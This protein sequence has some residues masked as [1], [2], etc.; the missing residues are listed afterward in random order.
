MG[1]RYLRFRL[2]I[3]L[4]VLV[5]WPGE[6]LHA[7]SRTYEYNACAGGV[8]QGSTLMDLTNINAGHKDGGT[9]TVPAPLE[10]SDI[11]SANAVITGLVFGQSYTITWAKNKAQV[12]TF[13]IEVPF[14]SVDFSLLNANSTEDDD[15]NAGA[16]HLFSIDPTT[17]TN[18]VFF[19]RDYPDGLENEEQSGLNTSLNYSVPASGVNEVWGRITDANGCIS[20]TNRIAVS[21]GAI[22]I[23]VEGGGSVCDP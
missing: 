6:F 9:W 13:N 11:Y 22:V 20:E 3:I 21:N 8:L 7:K 10:I 16:S 17:G 19:S 4:L 23:N 14:Q 18:Y 15:F 2:L 5:G 12:Y 1:S